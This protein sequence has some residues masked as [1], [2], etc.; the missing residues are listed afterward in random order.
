MA[1]GTLAALLGAIGEYPDFLSLAVF[2]HSGFHRSALDVGRA[3]FQFLVVVNRDHL[4]KDD[5]GFLS[6]IQFFD[7]KN[8]SVFHLI[9]LAAGFNDGIHNGKAPAVSFRLAVRGG[10]KRPL[11]RPGTCGNRHFIM[12][13]RL[14]QWETRIFPASSVKLG[15]DTGLKW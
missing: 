5:L 4:I 11:F 10:A 7:E 2:Q 3:G 6:S 1:H 14:C 8:V 13:I 12:E 9:L 15:S